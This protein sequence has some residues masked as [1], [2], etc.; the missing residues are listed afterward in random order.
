MKSKIA[1]SVFSLIFVNFSFA[2]CSS[3]I[4]DLTYSFDKN[5]IYWPTEK[6]FDLKT[7]SYGMT[8][9]NYFYSAFKFYAP[10]HGGTHLDA[11]HHYSKNGLTVDK[12][13]PAQ[14]T[15]SALVIK[16][17]KQAQAKKDYAITVK[18]IQN[19]EK[20]YRPL[21]NQDIVLFYTGWSKYWNNKKKYLGSD[22]PGDTKNLHFP[23]LSK[24]AAEYLVSRKIKGVGLD[25][26]SLDPGN[27][28]DFLAHRTLLG[29]NLFG[30]EN[31]D[32]LDLLPPIG[33]TIIVAPMKIAGGS[34]GPA[35][36]FVF[37]PAQNNGID[38]KNIKEEGSCLIK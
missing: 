36:V 15:G 8:P 13:L 5:T 26:A 38:E 14:L 24:D 19:F 3:K 20:K 1:A 9:D 2:H 18:D 10:E 4:V 11:P 22:K 25:T 33:A 23:G 16:I 29:A 31:L 7:V 12:I 17:N 30:I 34:G 21:S 27:S 32:K 35:R 6:G 28:K 37:V